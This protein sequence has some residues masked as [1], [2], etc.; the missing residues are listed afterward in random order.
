MRVSAWY[1]HLPIRDRLRLIVMLSVGVALVATCGT[2]LTY[3]E[4]TFRADMRNDLGV[5]A[6]MFGSNSTAALSFNDRQTAAELLSGFRAKRHIVSADL[7]SV[8]GAVF[9]SYRRDPGPSVAAPEL[10]PEGS[11]FENDQLVLFKQVILRGQ[12][13]G[14]VYLASDLGELHDRIKRFGWV[15]LA[16]MAGAALFALAVSS[17]LQRVISN[18]IAALSKA[19]NLVSLGKNYSVR[20]TKHADD[21]L[22]RLVDTFNHMLSEI[23]VR[24]AAL[25]AH[26]DQLE[27]EV[28]RRTVELV[29]AKDQ[30]GG[31]Q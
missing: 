9:A 21:E 27:V 8:D 19:A 23:E 30:S 16:L 12:P 22:G 5:L 14:T 3:E 2:I 31:R 25:L 29:E 18:P 15:V 1:F 28:A 7:Y 11:W 26:Q 17:W 6:E 24:D 13:I 10:R 20:A 4:V